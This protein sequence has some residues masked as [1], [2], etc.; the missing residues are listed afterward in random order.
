MAGGVDTRARQVPNQ[1][2]GHFK[3]YVG[4]P[5]IGVVLLIS[6]CTLMYSSFDAHVGNDRRELRPYMPCTAN[7]STVSE[8][9]QYRTRSEV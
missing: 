6:I 8:D 7:E 9:K 4:V 5:V 1:G 2:V 3:S